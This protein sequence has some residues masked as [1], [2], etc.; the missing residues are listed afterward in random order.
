MGSDYGAPN[1]HS[2][3]AFDKVVIATLPMNPEFFSTLK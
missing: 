1:A 2:L 3:A